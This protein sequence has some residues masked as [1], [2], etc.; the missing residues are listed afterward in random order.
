MIVLAQGV[1]NALLAVNTP[2]ANANTGKAGEKGEVI[3]G[4][5]AGQSVGTFAV[6]IIAD[7]GVVVVDG[8]VD[9]VEDV[10]TEH[11]GQGHDTPVL[12][13]TPDTEGVCGQRGED[14]E[15]EPVCNAC[16]GGYDDER[17]RVG[18]GGAAELGEC[19]D[20]GGDEETPEAG[21]VEFL[22]EDIGADTWTLRFGISGCMRNMKTGV[23]Y[24]WKDVQESFRTRG[25]THASPGAAG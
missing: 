3:G 4:L 25:W 6:A 17:V 1:V 22:D 9:K 11:W 5:V 18:D 8:A 19:E 12:G 20:H 16:E 7:D 14:T 24:R 2:Q 21:H 13:K 15:Q 23:A 10:S